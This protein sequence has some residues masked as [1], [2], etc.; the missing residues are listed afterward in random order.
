MVDEHPTLSIRLPNTRHRTALAT[1]LVR[2]LAV[3]ARVTPLAAD[4]FARDVAEAVHAA[5]AEVVIRVADSEPDGLALELWC[6]DRGWC[7]STAS[8]LVGDHR[9]GYVRLGV[10][11]SGLRPA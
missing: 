9:P 10:R 4:R 7:E 6:S 1:Y 2:G 8:R 11:R 3:A 5:P